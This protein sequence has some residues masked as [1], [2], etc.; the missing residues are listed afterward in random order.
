MNKRLIKPVVFFA[1][2]LFVVL[3]SAFYGPQINFNSAYF[4][5]LDN[6]DVKHWLQQV[7]PLE[8]EVMAGAESRAGGYVANFLA[9]LSEYW[10]EL[11][12]QYIDPAQNP[13]KIREYGIK[14][15]GEMVIHY[16]QDHFV[17]T[18]LSYETLFNGLQRLLNPP[19]GWLVMLDGFGA[20]SL[21]AD[22]PDG[23]GLW[24]DTLQRL[25][26]QVAALQWR[27]DMALPSDVKVIILPNPTERLS[28][29]AVLW[30]QQQLKRGISIWWLNN[31]ESIAEQQALTV[32]FDVLPSETSLAEIPALTQYP[33]H[34]VTEHFSYPTTWRG[35]VS[36]VGSGDVVLQSDNQVFAIS[37]ERTSSRMLVVGDSDFINNSLLNSGGNQAL[38]LRMLDWLMHHDE[39]INLPD[40]NAQQVGL[41]LSAQ[42]VIVL[43]GV[44]LIGLP[45]VWLLGALI[46]WIINSRTYR[47]DK[48]E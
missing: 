17:L 48:K 35:V 3:L 47:Q 22:N 43:S 9:P 5:D 38:S 14:A 40:L 33:K 34:A 28:E 24:I 45:L 2:F 44:M 41:F 30:L 6:T 25:N 16:Q 15:R 8:I 1:S 27:D 18:N 29:Q 10:S 36:F 32:M 7:P 21:R 37:Q 31:S 19:R 13:E 42:Q 46:V 4:D 12:I 26:Y 20:Q 11:T 23:L 39:R